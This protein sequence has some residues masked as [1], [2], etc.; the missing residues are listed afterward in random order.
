MRNGTTLL[1]LL[2]V[3]LIMAIV[4][5]VS[6]LALRPPEATPPGDV[7]AA[8]Q[9]ARRHAL[10]LG[11]TVDTEVLIGGRSYLVTLLP[12]GRAIADTAVSLNRLSGAFPDSA[13]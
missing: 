9:T 1:E 2:V 8:I 3:I 4:A 7:G 6:V 5:G 13:P 10:D 12:D 11:H